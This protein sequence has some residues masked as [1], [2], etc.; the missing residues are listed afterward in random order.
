VGVPDREWGERVVAC[1]VAADA[2]DAEELLAWAAERLAPYKRPR[3]VRFVDEL[4][5]NALG[6]VVRAAL[7]S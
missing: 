4:P 3:E 1:I 7:V 2:A 6:K 5:R